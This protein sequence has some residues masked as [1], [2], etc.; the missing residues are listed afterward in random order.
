MNPYH[1]YFFKLFFIRFELYKLFFLTSWWHFLYIGRRGS[2]KLE[3]YRSGKRES[4]KSNVE[5]LAKEGPSS[6]THLGTH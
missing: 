2:K 3:A 5:E 6:Q 4:Y 1:F